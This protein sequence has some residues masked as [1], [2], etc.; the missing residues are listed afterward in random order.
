MQLGLIANLGVFA[1]ALAWLA[2]RRSR[3]ASLSSTVLIGLLLGVVAGAA[4]QLAYGHGSDT[5]TGTVRWI[6]LV[7]GGYVRLLQMIVT[8]L[9]LVS[10][11]S[12]VTRLDDARSLGRISAGVL[13][14]L[15]LTTAASAV[16]GIGVARLFGLSARGLVQG[17]RELER[18]AAIQKSAG[19]FGAL[20]VP[21]MLLGFIPTNP[22][23]DLAGARPTSLIAVVVFASLLG[24][25]ALALRRENPGT[26]G[27]VIA[28]IAD[29]QALVVRLVRMVIRLTPYGVLA[30]MTKVVA[31]SNPADILGLIR[32]V[33]ASYLGLGLILVAHA[34]LLAL[35]GINPVDHFRKT[36]PVLTFAFSSRSSAAAI[37]LNVETQT[38]RL[39]VPPAIANFAAS[40]GATIGQNGCAG[41]YPAMLAVMIAPTVGIDPGSPQFLGT[42]VLVVTL[43]SFGIAG[44]GG[45]ATFAAILVLSTLNLPVALAGLLISIEPLIDMGRT[46]VNVSGAMTAGAVTSR[47]LGQT[48]SEPLADRGPLPAAD[49]P[50]ADR[51]SAAPRAATD[52][53]LSPIG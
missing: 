20:D 14:T 39:G 31:T 36:W 22:F 46:A 4:L 19:E 6:N 5:V 27:R 29:V 48:V 37:P 8:P 42:L 45:G 3:G 28:A 53:A 41:L 25:A 1:L 52:R 26:G 7:G 24:I 47:L 23:A 16:I 10:I 35:A 2:R 17:A 15:M 43:S 33:L 49:R 38:S 50:G 12:A 11:L 13:G 34:A 40:F 18:G 44:V 30:L 21:E 9:V 51:P 32:F